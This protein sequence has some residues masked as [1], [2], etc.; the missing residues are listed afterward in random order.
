LC[1][2]SVSSSHLVIHKLFID[3]ILLN[4]EPDKMCHS[5]FVNE[6]CQKQMYFHSLFDHK[7]SEMD[8]LKH[9]TKSSFEDLCAPKFFRTSCSKECWR[10]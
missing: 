9:N 7:A 8:I 5:E 2:V 4:Q 1:S 3:G 6:V 10:A